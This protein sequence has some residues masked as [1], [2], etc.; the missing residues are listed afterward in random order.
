MNTNTPQD[1]KDMFNKMQE[2]VATNHRLS[3]EYL[4]DIVEIVCGITERCE[5][6]HDDTLAEWK[7][8]KCI[9]NGLRNLT[10]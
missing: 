1:L 9:R 3:D 5:A 2:D 6:A 8:F 7:G 4:K 10:K